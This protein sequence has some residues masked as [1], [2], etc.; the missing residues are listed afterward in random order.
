PASRP[1]IPSLARVSRAPGAGVAG[2]ASRALG[3]T[4]SRTAAVALLARLRQADPASPAAA[5]ALARLGTEARA[6]VGGLIDS[7]ASKKEDACPARAV[8]ERL[9]PVA[10]PGLVEA[11]KEKD[12]QLRDGASTVLGL[13]GPRARQAAPAV[14]DLLNDAE[15][16]VVLAAAAALVRIAP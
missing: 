9:G 8:L 3:A 4:R 7:L 5:A 6:A 15:P 16:A 11:L 13:M 1:A 10:V 12:P 14:E 2:A